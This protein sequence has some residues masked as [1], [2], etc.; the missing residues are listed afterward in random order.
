MIVTERI[1]PKTFELLIVE[2][3]LGDVTLLKEVLRISR[4]P[5]QVKVVRNG[6]DAISFLK[7]EGPFVNEL[8][9]DMILLDLNLPK[10]DGREVLVRIKGDERWKHIPVLIL[11]SSKEDKDMYD[12]YSKNADFYIQKPMD[13]D[14]YMILMKHIEDFCVGQE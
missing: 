14:H 12:S 5:I 8:E 11:T 3:N 9:P 2:D 7:K 10:M 4:F 1:H 13:M 6:L